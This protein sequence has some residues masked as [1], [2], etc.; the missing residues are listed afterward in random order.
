MCC[1]RGYCRLGGKPANRPG[2]RLVG[3]VGKNRPD[4]AAFTLIELLVVI[5]IITLLMALLLP[6]LQ[7]VRNQARAVA[8]QSKLR[9]WGVMFY[10]YSNDNGGELPYHQNMWGGWPHAL[11]SYY[12]DTNDLLFCPMAKRITIRPDNPIPAVGFMSGIVGGKSAAW[13]YRYDLGPWK[14]HFSGSYGINAG[15]SLC[16]IR[17]DDPHIRGTMNNMPILLDCV[18]KGGFPTPFNSPPD[19]DDQFNGSLTI[20]PRGRILSEMTYFCTNRHNGCINGLF[21][22]FSVS[23]IGLK[24]LWTLRWHLRDNARRIADSPWTKAG[25]VLPEDWPQWMRGFKDY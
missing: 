19:Y 1:A 15:P 6:A 9:Q 25:G 5:S 14:A 3:H 17:I 4:G 10:M 20:N 2:G 18:Y 24:E 11:R 23:R 13:E 16:R 12:S 22:D 7:R 21:L 8:C